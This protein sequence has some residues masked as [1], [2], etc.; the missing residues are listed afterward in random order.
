M[1][2]FAKVLLMVSMLSFPLL[3]QSA[4]DPAPDFSVTSLRGDT[5]TLSDFQ[6]KVVFLYFFGYG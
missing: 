6:E 5:L 4:G 1:N 2:K 3:G